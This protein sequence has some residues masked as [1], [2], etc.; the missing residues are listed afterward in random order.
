HVSRRI[1]DGLAFAARGNIELLQKT[2][3]NAP[4]QSIRLA[5]GMSKSAFFAQLLSDVIGVP[6]EAVQVPESSAL[7]A[8]ICAGVGANL[9]AI[10]DDGAKRFASGRRSFPPDPVRR[11]AYQSHYDRWLEM[12]AAREKADELAESSAIQA[13]MQQAAKHTARDAS[14]IGALRPSILVTASVDEEALT[15]LRQLG[16]VR[17]ESF[18]EKLR[19]LAGED[20]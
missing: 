16:D 18:R 17:Y 19:L 9:S 10:I 7:G 14:M 11:S 12:R 6:V 20:L 2:A 15:A 4:A 1:V 5:G 3:Q 8:A 13:L